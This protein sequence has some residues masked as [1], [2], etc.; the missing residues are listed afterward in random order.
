MYAIGLNDYGG[1]EVL[2]RLAQPD[3][4][5]DIGE[6]SVKVRATGIKPVNIQLIRADQINEAYKRLLKCDVKYRFVIDCASLQ[7]RR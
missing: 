3:P 6:V 4:H 2:H 7:V 5:P 1:P